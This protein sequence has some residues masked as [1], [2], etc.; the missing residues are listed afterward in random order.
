MRAVAS[1]RLGM[2][3]SRISLSARS[4]RAR[5][6]LPAVRWRSRPTSSACALPASLQDPYAAVRANIV[7]NIPPLT[8][9]MSNSAF[10]QESVVSS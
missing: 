9:H 8:F 7:F 5:S 3:R 6:P 1:R 2:I 4:L 10:R